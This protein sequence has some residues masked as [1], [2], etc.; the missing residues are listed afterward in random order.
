MAARSSSAMTSALNRALRAVKLGPE[1]AATVALA[2]KYARL[3]DDDPRFLSQV[4][5]MLLEVLV[6]LRMTPKARAAL[7]KG[8]ASDDG[9]GG[10]GV[11]PRESA[12]AELER[13]FTGGAR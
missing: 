1:D 4:G 13:E 5:R 2:R 3:I 12:L 8:G 9:N 10:S 11:D 6:E 7:V